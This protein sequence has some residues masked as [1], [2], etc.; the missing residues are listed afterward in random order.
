VIEDTQWID[1]ASLDAL[2][3][4]FADLAERPWAVLM[5][6]R[7]GRVV[8]CATAAVHTVIDLEPLNQQ[9]RS[10]LR[11]PLRAKRAI[12]ARTTGPVDRAFGGIRCS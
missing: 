3:T 8:Q 11:Q 6:R 10:N 12:C 1:D 9:P 2:G 4:V 7:P 5:T